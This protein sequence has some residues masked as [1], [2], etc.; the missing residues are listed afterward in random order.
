MKR[1]FFFILALFILFNL[2]LGGLAAYGWDLF[3]KPGPLATETELVLKKGAGLRA[4]AAQLEAS[5]VIH[6]DIAFMFGV[7][8]NEQ[9]KKLKA[10]E[11]LFPAAISGEDVM[12]LLVAGKTIAHFIT[13]PEGL[14]SREVAALIRNAPVL[15]GPLTVSIPEGSILPETYHFTRGDTRN[16]LVKRMQ[17]ALQKTLDDLW[18]SAPKNPLIKS[19]QD[20]LILASIVEKETGVASERGRVAGVFLNRLARKMRL[21]SDPTVVYGITN[22]QKDL[23]RGISKKDLATVNDYNTYII[24]SLPKGPICNPGLDSLKAVLNP[25][26]SKDLYFVADGTGGHV[27]AKT[28]AEHNRNVRNWRKIERSRKK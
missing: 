28:L 17:R 11:Y 15:E 2:V 3:T 23:G 27:F 16:D 18:A 5:G 25:V 7:R 19:R 24:P 8:L 22:G 12:N 10:G 14:Q 21:Q 26:A 9:G 6:D 20:L 1:F 4:I 13:I